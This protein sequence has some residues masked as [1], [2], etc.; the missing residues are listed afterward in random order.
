[1]MSC[2]ETHFMIT[3]LFWITFGITTMFQL[4]VLVYC[5]KIHR[6][7]VQMTNVKHDVVSE[8]R[9][10]YASLVSR[11]ADLQNRTYASNFL[12]NKERS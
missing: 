11:M 9:K 8:E 1:M 5:I 12:K 2:E 10:N 7:L 3:E 6:R 4:C